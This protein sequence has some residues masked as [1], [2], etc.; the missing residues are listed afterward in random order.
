[1]NVK[2]FL[3]VSAFLAAMVC[4]TAS[5]DI[6]YV[7]ANAPGP[8]HDG[9]S[10]SSAYKYLSEAIYQPPSYGD[11]IWVAEGIYKPDE[12]RNDPNGTSNR[13]LKFEL[14]SGVAIYGGFPS[15]GGDW[16][17]RDPD[18]YETVLSVICMAMTDRISQ[19]IP[20]TATMW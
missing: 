9:S 7:D 4:V 5:G 18:V 11:E 3:L 1:M 14:I 2:A 16:Q 8:T 13:D 10:W 17:D 15:G 20:T 6:I 12:T 19:T